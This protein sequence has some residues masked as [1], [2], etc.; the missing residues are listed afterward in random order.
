MTDKAENKTEAPTT[1]QIKKT[2]VNKKRN[3]S[4]QPRSIPLNARA[5]IASQSKKIAAPEGTKKYN[6]ITVKLD[7]Y[8]FDL[9]RLI[10]A[11]LNDITIAAADVMPLIQ[12]ISR[13]KGYQDMFNAFVEESV[14]NVLQ[15]S[16]TTH[17]MLDI[18]KV[19]DPRLESRSKYI[20]MSEP[21]RF[22]INFFHPF[23]WNYIEMLESV[24]KAL[25]EIEKLTLTGLVGEDLDQT[26]KDLINTVKSTFKALM[27]ISKI[28]TRRDAQSVFK[29]DQFKVVQTNYR[30]RISDL[31]GAEEEQEVEQV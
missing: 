14:G 25:V 3:Q 4:T 26:R 11:D 18:I 6:V 5:R 24:D 21:Q 10:E 22:E 23:F 7:I 20:E 30:N 28:K 8:S 19:N 12:I 31:I 1:P 9:N 2:N 16:S 17:D 15:L 13:E 27:F 29:L